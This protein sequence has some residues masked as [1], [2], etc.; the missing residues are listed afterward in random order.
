[1]SIATTDTLADVGATSLSAVRTLERYGLDYC[2]GG[3]QSFDAACRAKGLQPEVIMREIEQAESTGTSDRDWQTAPL[4]E[5]ANYILA[6]HHEY[7]KLELPALG[8]RMDKVLAVHGS[9]DQQRLNRMAEV[10]GNVRSELE[11]HIHKEETMLFPFLEQ[12]GKAETA[13]RPMPPVP[14][15]TIAN[16][17]GVME[18]EHESAGGALVEL[19]QLASDYAYP[20]Y[21]CSTVRALYDGLKALE[22]DLHVHIH[23]ENNILFP[24]AIALER[25]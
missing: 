6:T 4:D 23:L 24:R 3:K 8:T 9:K 2:C 22:A 16:P 18:R 25:R 19:R 7:L 13:G 20:T 15:G 1:M 12:Y 14:F 5:L 21:A 10:F 17:I 11:L